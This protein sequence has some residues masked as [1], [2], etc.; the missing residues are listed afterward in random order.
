MVIVAMPCVALWSLPL[1]YVVLRSW[2]LL[3]H[4]MVPQ[5]WSSPSHPHGHITIMLLGHGNWTAKEEVSRK[6]KKES[7]QVE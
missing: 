6:K 5:L 7:V 3:S 2:W 1:H 4:R